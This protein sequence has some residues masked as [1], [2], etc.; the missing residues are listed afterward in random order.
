[1][2]PPYRFLPSVYD[3]WQ[4]SYGKDY[5]SLIL[6]RLLATTKTYGI[7]TGVM[8]DLACGTGTLALQMAGR[9]WRV[10]GI[11]GSEGMLQEARKKLVGQKPRITFLR[12]DLCSF[13]LPVRVYLVTSLFDSLNHVLTVRDLFAAFQRVYASLLPGGFFVFDVNNELCYKTA[14]MRT[15][16][17]HHADFTIILES[18]YNSRRRRGESHITIFERSNGQ[19]A[20]KTE[21][22]A[23]RFYPTAQIKELLRRAGFQVLE[24]TDF[25]FTDRPEVGKIKTWWVARRY[26]D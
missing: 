17:T 12:Q 22:V 16:V 7:R 26:Q 8:L 2:S 24:S 15:E 25:N 10:W 4:R 21:T 13:S 18:D 6:P 20:R 14:W 1:M 3:R 9:G 11:D 23:E 19:Y 5:T